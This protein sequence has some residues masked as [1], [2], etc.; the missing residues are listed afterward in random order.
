[1]N[2]ILG[3]YLVGLMAALVGF[4]V[5]DIR[6]PRYYAGK[7]LPLVR[8]IFGIL[9][10]AILWPAMIGFL[11]VGFVGACVMDWIGGQP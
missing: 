2:W 7:P 6:V 10:I 9:F 4:V 11:L 3:V 5:M 8:Q 1:M